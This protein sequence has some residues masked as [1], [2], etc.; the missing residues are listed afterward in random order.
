M[1]QIFESLKIII[2]MNL[3]GVPIFKLITLGVLRKKCTK[4]KIKDK[5]V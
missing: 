1:S 5:K 4:S 2:F 3:D